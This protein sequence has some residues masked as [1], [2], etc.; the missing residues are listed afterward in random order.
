MYIDPL[1]DGVKI[2][3][4]TD[5]QIQQRAVACNQKNKTRNIALFTMVTLG[6]TMLSLKFDA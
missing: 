4:L 5:E 1:E 6:L 2:E 3:D